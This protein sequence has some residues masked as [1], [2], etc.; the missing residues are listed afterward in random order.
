MENCR[1]N[2]GRLTWQKVSDYGQRSHGETQIACYERVIRP[3][4]RR[5]YLVPQTIE[6]LITFQRPLRMARRSGAAYARFAER[7]EESDNSG[8][9]AIRPRRFT[10]RRPQTEERLHRR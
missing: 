2:A 6:A 5:R 8:S 3:G 7:T 4:L 1:N 9:S 10:S